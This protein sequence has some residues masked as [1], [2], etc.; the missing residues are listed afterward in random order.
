MN[1]DEKIY[2]PAPS[3]GGPIYCIKRA[4]KELRASRY[5]ILRLFFR[6]VNAQFRQRILGYFGILLTPVATALG[7]ILMNIAGVL[8]PGDVGIPYPLYVLCGNM[9][10]LS[11][12]NALAH[13]SNSL[14]S[15]N[16]L[17]IRTGIPKL[18]LAISPLPNHFFQSSIQWLS[19]LVISF[20]LGVAPSWSAI[21]FIPALLPLVLIGTGIGLALAVIGVIAKDVST[22]FL[23]IFR[24]LMYATPVIFLAQNVENPLLQKLIAINPITYLIDFPRSLFYGQQLTDYT[25]LLISFCFSGVVFLV[26][27]FIFYL[28][29]GKIAERL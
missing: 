24:L 27:I 10:W 2:T 12:E 4:I 6:D 26:G 20:I 19:L 16:D 13:V 9:L 5:L 7:F 8:K 15:Q 1:S 23:L 22:I 14:Q 29:E 3:L 25:S 18:A 17:I 21:L 11:M 28:F